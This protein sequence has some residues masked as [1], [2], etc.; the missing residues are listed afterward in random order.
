[1]GL[2]VAQTESTVVLRYNEDA[3]SVLEQAKTVA[4]NVEGATDVQAEP[5]T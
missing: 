1:V 2:W 3:E 4:G 5:N